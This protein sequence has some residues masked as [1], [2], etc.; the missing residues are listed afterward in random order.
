MDLLSGRSATHEKNLKCHYKAAAVILA[1]GQESE[2]D[3]L[4][5]TFET[6]AQESVLFQ[7]AQPKEV[8]E[9]KTRAPNCL[10]AVGATER[11]KF[12]LHR[13]RG[14]RRRGASWP[15]QPAS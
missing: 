7:T 1:L 6:L 2:T 3:L 8:P 15:Y 11:L 4:N 10:Q 14:G 12:H 5:K 9:P 13:F